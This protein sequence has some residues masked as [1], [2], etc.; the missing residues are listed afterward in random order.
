MKSEQLAH[1]DFPKRIYGNRANAHRKNLFAS[2]NRVNLDLS[3]ATVGPLYIGSSCPCGAER[4]GIPTAGLACRAAGAVPALVL[5]RS[6]F[7]YD[8]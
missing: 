6:R 1:P 4:L 5:A 2:N 7:A 8:M 3:K